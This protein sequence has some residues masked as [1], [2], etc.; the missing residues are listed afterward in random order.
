MGDT[1]PVVKPDDDET[2]TPDQGSDL[3]EQYY[4]TEDE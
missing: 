3:G 1:D 4:Y 2:A